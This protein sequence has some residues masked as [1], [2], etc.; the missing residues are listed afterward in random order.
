MKLLFFAQAHRQVSGFLQRVRC[1]KIP[2][3]RGYLLSHRSSLDFIRGLLCLSGVAQAKRGRGYALSFYQTECL[4]E[5]FYGTTYSKAG[6]FATSPDS[7]FAMIPEKGGDIQVE[8]QFGNKKTDSF[9]EVHLSTADPYS[10]F[11]DGNQP[12]TKSRLSK[13]MENG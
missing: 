3:S 12:I 7:I 2:Q 11:L 10:V 5:Q 13:K 4:T 8:Y 9:Y 6:T 1:F